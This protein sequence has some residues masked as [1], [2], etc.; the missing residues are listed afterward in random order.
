MYRDLGRKVGSLF[1]LD[2]GG[3]EPFLRKDLAKIVAAFDC[4]IVQIPSNG[5]L[6]NQMIEQI[7]RMKEIED[8]DVVISLS[9][10]GPREVHDK[11]RGKAGSYDQ[12]WET[13]RRLRD[14][15][16]T[17]VKILSVLQQSNTD[18]I[19]PFME[20]VYA[21]RPDF[22]SVILFRGEGIDKDVCLPPLNQLKEL[23]P[24]IQT[25]Q[26]RYGYGKNRL[27]AHFLRKFHRMVWKTSLEILEQERQ[28]IPCLGGQSHMVIFGNGDVS[29]CEMLEP[30]GNILDERWQEITTGKAFRQQVKDIKDG[31]CHCTHNCALM[32]SILLNPKNI[33]NLVRQKVA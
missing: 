24:K 4:R 32:D 16:G 2:I 11:I 8:R 6:P 31:K 15:T 12:V 1:W 9:L 13:A 20:E 17:Y 21:Q 26:E 30:V 22:H 27:A 18:T 33:P 28:V 19:I 23:V 10:D 29:S 25:I 14:E 3:G 5:S 7:L